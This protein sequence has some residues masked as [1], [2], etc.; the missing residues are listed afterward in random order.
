MDLENRKVLLTT[1][2][3]TQFSYYPLIWMFHS[4]MLNHQISKI[5]ERALRLVY[6]NGN[7]SFTDLL[8][9]DSSVAIH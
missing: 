1:F 3:I 7:L 5:Q 8:E 4:R 2:M 9:P 6:Q